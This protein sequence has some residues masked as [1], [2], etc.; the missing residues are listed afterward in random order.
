MDLHE[1]VDHNLTSHAPSETQVRF[2]EIVRTVGKQ[3]GH[4]IVEYCP[5][6]REQSLA[7]TA[8][9]ETVMWAVAAIARGGER[10]PGLDPIRELPP[11][12]PGFA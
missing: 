6:G 7:L 3:L 8:L 5:P 9:E 2:I 1:R 10:V 11:E 12:A 4:Q